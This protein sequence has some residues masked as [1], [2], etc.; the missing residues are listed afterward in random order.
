MK[1]TFT[2]QYNAASTLNGSH[3]AHNVYS[4]L[5][6]LTLLVTLL[7]TCVLGVKA[8]QYVLYYD[9]GT[10]K[11]YMANVGNTL[12][13]LTD[14]NYNA[15]TCVWVGTSGGK[16]SNNG[17][18]IYLTYSSPY[19]KDAGAGSDLIIEDGTNNIYR[20]IGGT[21]AY[22]IYHATSANKLNYS[23]SN[24]STNIK[25]ATPPATTPE[26]ESITITPDNLSLSVGETAT[27]TYTIAPD[28]AYDEDVRFSIDDDAIAS[29]AAGVVTAKAA[30][31]TTLTVTAYDS[32]GGGACSATC[33]ITVQDNGPQ[34]VDEAGV[35]AAK[36]NLVIGVGYPKTTSAEYIALNELTANTKTQAEVNELITAYKTCADIM[37]PEDGKAYTFTNV[38]GDNART[39]R[40]IKYENGKKV[41]VSAN[42][43]DATVFVC[44][45]LSEG[46]YVFVA[47]D[48][49]ILTWVGN[50]ETGAYKENGNIYGYSSEY[51]TEYNGRSDWNKITIKKNKVPANTEEFGHVRMVARRNSDGVSAFIISNAENRFDQ[52]GDNYY[53]NENYSSAWLIVEAPYPTNDEAVKEALAKIDKKEGFIKLTPEPRFVAS[54]DYQTFTLTCTENEGVI[55]YTEDGSDPTV[56][57]SNRKVLTVGKGVSFSATSGLTVMAYAHKDGYE[58]SAVVTQ[59]MNIN[60]IDTA[61]KLANI[62]GSGIYVITADITVTNPISITN[63]TGLLDGGYH[64]IGGLTT[65]LFNSVNGAT[66]R[67]VVLDQVNITGG[68]GNVG[69]IVGTASGATR[70]YNCGV[71]SGSIGGGTN[72]GSIAGLIEGTARVINCYSYANITGGTTVGGIVGYNAT[73]STSRN[74]ET[75]VMNCMYY[76]NITE[77]TNKAPIY[78]GEIIT[79]VNSTNDTGI[80]NYNYY[81][82]SSAYSL[83]GKINTYNCAL[84]AE[85]RYLV[86]HEFY[87]G[88]LNSNKNLCGWYVTGQTNQPEII[89]K[90]VLDTSIAPYPII[91]PQ[92]RYRGL[93]NRF[94]T[95]KDASSLS[96]EERE[97]RILSDEGDG[98][99]LTVTVERGDNGS[100]NTI[101]LSL[102]I[103]D[104]NYNTYDYNYAKVVLPFYNQYFDGNYTDNKVVTGWEI[105]SITGGGVET[106]GTNAYNYADRNSEGKD[107]GRIFAQGGYYNVPKGVKAITIKAKWADAVYLSDEYYDKSGYNLTNLTVTGRRYQNG[108]EY[109]I[110]GSKQIVYTSLTNAINALSTG[111]TVYDKAIVLVGNYHSYGE[112]W[113]SGNKPFTLMS[114]DLDNDNEPDY[115]VFHY[116]NDRIDINPVRFDFLW[117]PGIGM[118]HK[119]NGATNMLN[120]GIFHPTGWFEIT[121][122]ALARYTEF[123]YGYGDDAPVILNNGIFEQFVTRHD[124]TTTEKAYFILGGNLYMKQF[125]PGV[126]V[127]NNGNTRHCPTNVLGGEYETFYLS[128]MFR[129]DVNAYNDEDVMCY[130]NGGKFG[131]MAGAGHEQIKGNIWFKID[132]SVIGEFYGG[133]INASKPVTGNINVQIDNSFVEKFCGGPMFGTMQTDK[134]VA[135][136]ANGTTFGRYYGA[137]NGGTSLNRQTTNGKG[138]EHTDY[139]WNNWMSTYYKSLRYN[140]SLGIEVQPEYEYFAYAGGNGDRNVGR[141]YVNYAKFDKAQTNNVSSTLINC[142]VLNDY[143]GGGNLGYV[144][145][146]VT[147][148]LDG[149]IVNGSV[150]GGGFSAT[151]PTV[152]VYPNGF[153]KAPSYNGN[154]GVYNL[155]EYYE[156]KEYTWSNKDG[157]SSTKLTDGDLIWSDV[158]LENLGEVG[159]NT[160]I[161]IKGN[162]QIAG[163]VYGGGNASNVSGM[164]TVNIEANESSF[165]NEVYGG[166]NEANVGKNTTVNILSGKIGKVFGANNIKGEKKE[167]IAVN[168]KGATSDYVYGAGNLAAYTGNPVVNMSAGTVKNALYGG[169]LG[170]SAIVTGNPQVNMTGGTVGYTEKVDGKDVVRGGDVFG[171]GNAAAVQGNTNVHIS[172]GEVKH[173]VYGGGNQANVTGKTNVVIGQQ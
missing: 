139:S 50:N 165:I 60:T 118:A 49:N 122:T 161:T 5:R 40:Y 8:E 22:I 116:H 65:P 147:S 87:R 167:G 142:T 4:P 51:A 9:D 20:N 125:S 164:T 71:L 43:N 150:Y 21:K 109:S 98:G 93:V 171:G 92:G 100:G 95:D 62:T 66:I 114:A 138:Y 88:I 41:S 149:C 57:T 132:N 77:G 140:S 28:G 39:K 14:E 146:N 137:G 144:N 145:G 155:G 68:T 91:K 159:G 7:V 70:I 58:P 158:P 134:Q 23:I 131:L 133:G 31:T 128:G 86:R 36:A 97:G 153:K 27:V 173:N 85:E 169:G 102:P 18:E 35:A 117:H 119:A 172:G 79:N 47:P 170:E 163:G 121:E 73:A 32:K 45:E 46:V 67:N 113:S 72:V 168:V 96:K 148:V 26:P 3:A 2:T 33:T 90:W 10:T 19:L 129:T 56:A 42:A 136:T 25:A 13:V 38:M 105:T 162:A 80:N 59:V 15:N 166:A 84:A 112:T 103:T 157:L 44:R 24:K 130:T 156:P 69:A 17:K 152:T 120:Q 34:F 89:G 74:L 104:M 75:I 126:H 6:R 12:T 37:L 110:N 52:A 107:K 154:V 143:Y 108:T 64:T 30:G 82:Y 94:I 54:S 101:T 76:G 160:T 78:N 53:F 141:F 135:T 1:T 81:R 123:E 115:C 61:E 16:F 83:N 124:N 63:F 106:T 111:S 151:I 11:Y 127:D 48:G 55:Y 29:I 99:Y